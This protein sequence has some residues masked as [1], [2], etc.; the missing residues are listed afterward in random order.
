MPTSFRRYI[1]DFKNETAENLTITNANYALEA[2]SIFAKRKIRTTK[3]TSKAMNFLLRGYN[4][5]ERKVKIHRP[6]FSRNT[7]RLLL[8]TRLKDAL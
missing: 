2:T 5:R 3:Y 6:Y 8:A 7:L 4:R 1:Y